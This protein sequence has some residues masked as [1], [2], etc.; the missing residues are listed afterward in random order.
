MI[1]PAGAPVGPVAAAPAIEIIVDVATDN[2]HGQAERKPVSPS[3]TSASAQL[4]PAALTTPALSARAQRLS[5]WLS[6]AAPAAEAQAPARALLAA[7]A[8]QPPKIATA[9]QEAIAQSGLFYESHLEEWVDGKRSI[10]ALRQE[11]QA[12]LSASAGSADAEAVAIVR[13]QLDLL[14]TQQLHWR[15]ELWPGLP[16]VLQVAR[17]NER[18]Q[19][20]RH[21]PKTDADDAVWRSTLVST[22][23]QLG[24]VRL[25]LRLSENQLQLIVQASSESNTRLLLRDIPS[26]ARALQQA[27]IVLDSVQ[28]HGRQSD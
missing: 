20:D 8:D 25:R 10:D 19:Q 24:E 27:G 17:E 13:R 26:L 12:R 28:A 23:P 2:L 1:P 9:L 7:P 11:P 4:I 3:S 21:T 18:P 14:D 16:L 22:L 6:A 5:S 15:G